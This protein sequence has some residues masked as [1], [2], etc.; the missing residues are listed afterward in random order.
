MAK[1]PTLYDGDIFKLEKTIEA[2]KYLFDKC[3]EGNMEEETTT[4]LSQMG[5]IYLSSIIC[6]LQDYKNKLYRYTKETKI[7]E[8]KKNKKVNNC[9]W[10]TEFKGE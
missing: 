7:L 3:Y 5:A 4:R 10:Y 9:D 6:D 2:L 1:I 8:I